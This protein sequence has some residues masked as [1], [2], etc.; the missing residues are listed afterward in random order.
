[1]KDAKIDLELSVTLETRNGTI[2]LPTT[3]DD[4][5]QVRS[6]GI[7]LDGILTFWEDIICVM[8]C[9]REYAKYS[10]KSYGN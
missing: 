3:D 4:A 2:E 7:Y 10:N 6:D 5:F 9:N 1:M 8:I